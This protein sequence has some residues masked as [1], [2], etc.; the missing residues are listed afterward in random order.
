M[1]PGDTAIM[2]M[3]ISIVTATFNRAEF[4]GRCIESIARQ[5]YADKEHIIID[6]GSTDGTVEVIREYAERYPHIRWKSEKDNGISDAFNKGLAMM[7]GDAVGIIGDDDYYEPD[8]FGA[9]AEAFQEHPGVGIVAGN[10]AQIRND[11]SVWMVLRASF[12]SRRDLIQCWKH[13]GRATMLP[14]PSSF[15]LRRAI[16]LAGGFD[17]ADRYAMDYHHWIKITG[18]FDVHTIDRVL[19]NF[20]CD[21]GTVSFSQHEKQWQET[22]AI[23]K[24]YWGGMFDRVYYEMLFSYL[25]ECR[26]PRAGS[27][28]A[29]RIRRARRVAARMLRGEGMRPKGVAVRENE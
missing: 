1:V 10:C 14:A 20:R 17:L 24:R 8:I 18:K 19:A 21:E 29:P 27:F 5:P 7:T 16:D 25:M 2:G 9:V 26:Y 23:S 15:I 6:G 11:G 3:K 22:L 28:L 13:W 12:S 4:I